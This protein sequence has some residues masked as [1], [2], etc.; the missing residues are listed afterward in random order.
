MQL[1]DN[2]I[3]AAIGGVHTPWPGLPEGASFASTLIY[4]E[5]W[6]AAHSGQVIELMDFSPSD[7]FRSSGE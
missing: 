4:L 7:F 1:G 6:A 2:P 3:P 5:S